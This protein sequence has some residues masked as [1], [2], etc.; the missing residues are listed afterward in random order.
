MPGGVTYETLLARADEET[1]RA[2]VGE[3]V[4]QLL[5]LLDPGLTRM[6]VLRQLVNGLHTPSQILRD[7]SARSNL[8]MLT[9]PGEAVQLCRDL[10]L[11]V[12]DSSP[13][14]AFGALRRLDFRVGSAFERRLYNL[15]GVTTD[16]A[17]HPPSEVD[18]HDWFNVEP[19]YGLYSH[20]RVAVERTIGSLEHEPKRVLLH[21]PT[22][23]GKTRVAMN[24]VVDHLKSNEPS[25]VVWL[26]FSEEL[27]EQAIQEFQ[28]AW[29]KL[30][31]RE[32]RAQRFWGAY[33]CDFESFSDGFVVAGLGKMYNVARSSINRIANLADKVKFV[34]LDEAH[35]AIAETYAL[36]IDVLATKRQETQ[37]LGLTATPGRTWADIDADEEL[38]SFFGSNKVTLRVDGFDNPIDYL[39]DSGFLAHAEFRSLFYDGGYVPTQRDLQIV[40]QSLDIPTSVLNRIAEDERRNL[41]IIREL[42]EL[43]SSHSRILFFAA[44]VS[45]AKTIATVLKARGL[46][47]SVVT[48]ETQTLERSRIIDRFRGTDQATQILCNYGVLTTG[49]DAPAT[50]AAVIARPTNSLILYSQM[51]GRAIRGPQVGGTES[52]T[53]VTVV[54]RDLPGFSSVAES[55]TNWEDVWKEA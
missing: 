30:G 49:F 1:L 10:A 17:P 33:D 51:V 53:I 4:L 25:L 24:V 8:L 45:H 39:V 55:F 27:C 28:R 52:C 12:P 22:G 6:S 19:D 48:G 21:M 32:L 36:T 14:E 54:D 38:A 2:L 31:N 18:R 3:H 11:S 13:T 40:A 37:L 43:A 29:S 23:S 20:Q 47:A 35:V 41:V 44:S 50:S 16:E 9:R 46:D 5:R 26:A 15:L 42:E 34:I 7:V